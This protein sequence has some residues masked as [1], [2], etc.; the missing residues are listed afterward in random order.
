MVKTSLNT[1]RYGI[2][3]TAVSRSLAQIPGHMK[4]NA[5]DAVVAEDPEEDVCKRQP[6]IF[7]RL[8]RVRYGTFMISLALPGILAGVSP[9]TPLVLGLA[10]KLLRAIL[11][12]PFPHEDISSRCQGT[13]TLPALATPYR[14]AVAA[15]RTRGAQAVERSRGLRAWRKGA[16]RA[17]EPLAPWRRRCQTPPPRSPSEDPSGAPGRDS[18][19]L[20]A[21]PRALCSSALAGRHRARMAY[22]RCLLRCTAQAYRVMRNALS[23]NKLYGRK[24][25]ATLACLSSLYGKMTRKLVH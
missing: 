20:A 3:T 10:S 16:R 5:A 8:L 4:A 11:V 13:K 23:D 2:G 9:Q 24:K 22:V 14:L 6:T 18:P 21:S 19:G 15:V 7:T 17:C 1:R 25:R 12:S